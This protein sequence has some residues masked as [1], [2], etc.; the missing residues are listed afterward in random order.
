YCADLMSVDSCCFF[1]Q[2]EDGIRYYKVTGVQTCAL[3]ISTALASIAE[4]KIAVLPFK[5]LV[6][7]NRDQVLELGMAD[8]LIAKLSNIREMEIGRASCGKEWRYGWAQY[9]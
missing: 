2:A 5:P 7:D 6:P 1:F 3:P 9:H 4:K 8:S